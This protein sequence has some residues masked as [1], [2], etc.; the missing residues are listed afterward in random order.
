MK[1]KNFAL[2]AAL[3]V[4]VASFAQKDEVKSADKALK[5]GNAEEAK[6]ILEKVESMIV[7]SDDALKAQYYFVLGN[8]N[9]ELAKAKKEETKNLLGA[10]SAYNH[11]LE[12]EKN[13]G[14]SKYTSQAQTNLTEVKQLLRN[15]AVN[16]YNAKKYKESAKKLYEV[17]NLDKKDTTMLYY[18]ASTA[19]SGQDYESALDYYK[20]LKD[21]NYSGKATNYYAKN[22]IS[23]QEETFVNKV[24]RDQAVKLGSHS[25]PRDEKIESK[26]GEI[27]KNISLIL[28]EKG[29]VPAAKKAVSDARKSNPNDVSLIMSEAD[30]YLKTNDYV[31]YKNLISEV[32]AKDPNNADLY[33]NLGVISSQ[34]KDKQAKIDAE[35][36]YL[37]TIQIDP[38][39]KNAYINLAVLKLEGEKEIVEAINK[40]T[41]S[42]ADS[43]KYTAL[44]AKQQDIYKSTIPF[45]EKAYDLF[46]GDKDIKSTL[47]N[48]YNA[49]DLT[50]K[51][52]ALKAK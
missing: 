17:Y 50:E 14:K 45:L 23:D 9:L 24:T 28:I 29:D 30:L 52:K 2:A 19:L 12:V 31:T 15:D 47:L 1:I 6:S 42:P 46:P 4:S 25:T 13:S 3:F 8:S 40:L 26:R 7:N 41:T 48:M 20:K 16:D 21:I 32:L 49:L 43:K 34:S 51:A 18:A 39:Y 11:L 44:K 22:K 33:Y 10:A 37:K 27:A 38:K 35:G 36:Y 5:N